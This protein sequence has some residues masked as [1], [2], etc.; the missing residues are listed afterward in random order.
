MVCAGGNGGGIAGTPT[1]SGG[2]VI[3]PIGAPTE[4]AGGLMRG[5]SCLFG[6]GGEQMA[7]SQSSV[8]SAQDGEGYGS[9]GC[10]ATSNGNAAGGDGAPG[11]F[12]IIE[13]G[14]V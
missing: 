4:T 1:G 6:R 7:Y 10:G 11:F 3:A 14:T 8:I 12:I 2:R 5:G 9:G 13:F